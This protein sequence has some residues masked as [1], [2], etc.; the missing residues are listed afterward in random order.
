MGELKRC[1]NGLGVLHR[2]H[3]GRLASIYL[4]FDA[5][6]AWEGPGESGVAHLLE[7]MLFK[8]SPRYG[9]GEAA[10]AIEGLGGDLNAYTTWDQT[11]LHATVLAEGWRETLVILADMAWNSSLDPEELDREK[12]VVI[13]E[14]RGYD[15]DPESVVDDRMAAELFPGSAYG[16]P[17]LGTVE[18]V[19]ALDRASLFGFWQKNYGASRC[20]IAIAGPMHPAEIHEAVEALEP[21]PGEPFVAPP[22]PT[23][24]TGGVHRVE[25]DFE[26]SLLSVGFLL[27]GDGHPDNPAIE[28]LASTLGSGR[29]S[30]LSSALRFD[31]PLAADVWCTSYTRRRCGSLEIGCVPMEGREQDCLDAIRAVVGRPRTLS[32]QAIERGRANL[33]TDLVFAEEQIE[34]VA[35]D[36][37]WFTRR[38]TSLSGPSAWREAIRAVRPDD[39]R[40]VAARWLVDPTVV[41]LGEAPTIVEAIH[42]GPT[43]G[44]RVMRSTGSD[45]A[46]DDSPIAS[47]FLGWNGGIQAETAATAGHTEAWAAAVTQ[48]AG[49]YG[50]IAFAGE[51]DRLGASIRIIPG[52]NTLGVQLTGPIQTFDHAVD[53]LAQM[54]ESPRFDQ[55]DLD[56][57]RQ[58]GLLELDTLQD[59]AGDILARRLDQLAWK[60]HPWAVQRSR[61]RLKALRPPHLVEHHTRWVTQAGLVVGA[62]GRVDDALPGWIDRLAAGLPSDAPDWTP[63]TLGAPPTGHHTSMGGHDQALVV[64][65]T[66]LPSLH[67]PDTAALRI[68]SALLGAQ[69]GPL[70]LDLRERRSLAYSVWSRMV[71]GPTVGL[72]TVGLATEP[73]RAREAR[74][75][76]LDALERFTDVGPTEQELARTQ[77]ATLGQL[78]SAD[79]SASGRALRLALAGLYGLEPGSDAARREI[80]AVTTADVRRAMAALAPCFTVTVRPRS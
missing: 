54:L 15:D 45:A 37:A 69:S 80:E 33:L 73:G 36:L 34:N 48:G 3:P 10:S 28:V 9:V 13:E 46:L 75:A 50:S 8:G 57:L 7:H 65:A 71:E 14:I 6:T 17:V 62:S 58:E 53:L 63:P 68:A 78:A 18:S 39:V 5:G 20:V 52:R 64:A 72:L 61:T 60:G 4:W 55:S 56:R 29:A 67:H 49:P 38:E 12:P 32:A 1:R 30:L 40:R 35:H 25:R 24:R 43:T 76:L 42:S 2:H 16:R 79:Q 22:P 19:R 70:F 51:L 23:S 41:V 11:V 59:R 74:R 26:T 66:R 21:F 47:V 27:P 44:P 77:A 31:A